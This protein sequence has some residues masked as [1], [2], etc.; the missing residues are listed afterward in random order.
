[1]SMLGIWEMKDLLMEESGLG[2]DLDVKGSWT[3]HKWCLFLS[4]LAVLALGI[5]GVVGCVLTWFAGMSSFLL[6]SPR[7]N[8]ISFLFD[9]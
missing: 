5:T 3:I 9:R 2:L 6:L 7:L 8:V 1:M 4:V